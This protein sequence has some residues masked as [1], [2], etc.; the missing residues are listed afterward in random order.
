MA[1]AHSDHSAKIGV[2]WSHLRSCRQCWR[3]IYFD[4]SMCR[5]RGA[6]LFDILSRWQEPLSCCCL[7]S[8]GVRPQTDVARPV[9]MTPGVRDLGCL[10]MPSLEDSALV[11]GHPPRLPWDTRPP[12]RTAQVGIPKRSGFCP[13]RFLFH[14]RL[15][16]R[17]S[18][19]DALC[20]APSS[21]PSPPSPPSQAHPWPGAIHCRPAPRPVR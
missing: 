20:S 18:A 8:C 1:T 19:F 14:P 6:R 3:L 15:S 10:V 17:F 21:P 12:D 7:F 2:R 9:F 11:H 4:Y 16:L 13:G 5:T